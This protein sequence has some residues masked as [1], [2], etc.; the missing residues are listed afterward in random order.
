MRRLVKGSR[1]C[2]KLFRRNSDYRPM[3]RVFSAHFVASRASSKTS[4]ALRNL[5]NFSQLQRAKA[6]SGLKNMRRRL[7]AHNREMARISQAN[8]Y[9]AGY[10]AANQALALKM[11]ELALR[12]QECIKSANR[13]CLDLALRVASKFIADQLQQ[14]CSHLAALIEAEIFR[15][16]T[17]K[18]LRVVVH[19]SQHAAMRLAVGEI[20][21]IEIACCTELDSTDVRIESINGVVLLRWQERFDLLAKALK[22]Q[23]NERL[24]SANVASPR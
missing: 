24:E 9:A 6:A 12:E 17:T 13:S 19:P 23:L 18:I 21:S 3:P 4:Q 22:R 7:R 11:Q 16:T 15:L 8:G 14:N 2:R 1:F 10:E 20:H 5:I